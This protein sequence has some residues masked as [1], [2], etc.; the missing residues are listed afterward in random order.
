M[1]NSQPSAGDDL[2]AI[3]GSPGREPCLH[4]APGGG[5]K[6]PDEEVEVVVS[7]APKQRRA[8]TVEITAR[9]KAQP[10]PLIEFEAE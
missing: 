7:M 5:D 1:A 8:V 2:A 10:R 4:L 3:V 6:V 9:A